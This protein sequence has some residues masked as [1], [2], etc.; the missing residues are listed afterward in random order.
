MGRIV[1]T[2]IAGPPKRPR[3]RHRLVARRADP[4]VTS[5]VGHPRVT[6]ETSVDAVGSGAVRAPAMRRPIDR[7]WITTGEKTRT[8]QSALVDAP[9]DH[10]RGNQRWPIRTH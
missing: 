5:E 6:S 4:V 2:M 3:T 9:A 7:E 1:R 10:Q 8:P